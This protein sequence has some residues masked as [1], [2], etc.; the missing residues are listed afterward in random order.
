VVAPVARLNARAGAGRLGL[1]GAPVLA[2]AVL[3]AWDPARNGGPPLCALRAA[4]G[5]PCPT[6]GL[7]RAAASLL[8]GRWHEAVSLH[9]LIPLLTVEAVAVWLVLCG[10]RLGPVRVRHG[11]AGVVLGVLAAGNAVALLAVWAVRLR[12]GGIHTSG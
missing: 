4:T 11:R 12:T 7:T 9:P 6:C 10:A 3:A 1:V 5:V 8:R 2:A